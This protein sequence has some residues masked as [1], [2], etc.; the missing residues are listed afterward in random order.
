M[1]DNI[2]ERLQA[3]RTQQGEAQRRHAQAEAKL[4]TVRSRKD[5]LLAGL[6]EQGF[7]TPEQARKHVEELN[8]EVEGILNSI[9]DKVKGL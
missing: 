2:E 6:Q 1:A 7:D 3:L 8:A 4:D 5:S 9:E